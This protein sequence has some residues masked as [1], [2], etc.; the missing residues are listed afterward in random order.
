[1]HPETK[2]ILLAMGLLGVMAAVVWWMGVPFVVQTPGPTYNVLGN[3][4]AGKPVIQISG[5][6]DYPDSGTLR[7]VTVSVTSPWL[8]KSTQVPR[9]RSSRASW[10]LL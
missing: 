2:A 8:T 5:A 10:A 1:M 3:N 7:M 6:T 9:S 4:D